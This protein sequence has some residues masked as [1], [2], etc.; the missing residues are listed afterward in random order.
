MYA[1]SY[2]N[3]QATLNTSV[4]QFADYCYSDGNSD[5]TVS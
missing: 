1:S 2:H 5:V 3:R 4:P